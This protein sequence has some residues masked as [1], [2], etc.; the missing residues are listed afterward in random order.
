MTLPHDFSLISTGSTATATSEKTNADKL[1]NID[2]RLCKECKATLFDRRDFKADIMRKPA[3][4]RAYENLTQF[5]RGIRLHLPR[6]QK[7]LAA[8]QYVFFASGVLLRH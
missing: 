1:V 4:I 7:L 2:V 8:L 3:E 6:F 5:E